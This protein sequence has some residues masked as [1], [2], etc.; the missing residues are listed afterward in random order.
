[1]NIKKIKTNGSQNKNGNTE[2]IGRR[3]TEVVYGNVAWLDDGPMG[4]IMRKLG[5]EALE[6][7][8]KEVDA[9]L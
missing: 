4:F 1:M 3:K 9:R 8:S 5:P 2:S 6:E 7:L